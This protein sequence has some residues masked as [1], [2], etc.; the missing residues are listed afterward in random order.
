M[1]RLRHF[2][3]RVFIPLTIATGIYQKGTMPM[4]GGSTAAKRFPPE[5]RVF[6]PLLV[7][8]ERTKEVGHDGAN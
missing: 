2:L 1:E 5:Q 3:R 7:A 4:L 6:F 8:V